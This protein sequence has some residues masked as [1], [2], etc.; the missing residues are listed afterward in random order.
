[1][2]PTF[3]DLL[4]GLRFPNDVTQYKD[5]SKRNGAF[6]AT[7]PDLTRYAVYDDDDADSTWEF[8]AP[9]SPAL[10]TRPKV[11]LNAVTGPTAAEK[12]ALSYRS[13]DAVDSETSCS[14]PSFTDDD[15]SSDDVADTGSEP[16]LFERDPKVR[17][18]ES[19][20]EAL[21]GFFQEAFAE[22]D[23]GHSHD[24]Q[25]LVCPR[26]GCRDTLQ[27][28]KALA[29]HLHLHDILTD[30]W[31]MVFISDFLVFDD[32]LIVHSSANDATA[33]TIPTENFNVTY[34]HAM[35]YNPLLRVLSK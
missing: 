3:Q 25:A 5:R 7:A 9:I 35:L 14:T 19:R 8:N 2:R 21:A 22:M 17:F 4:L 16:S 11:T 10:V 27:N 32:P 13:G 6:F 34:A 1:M 18:R 31:A 29:Y 26:S 12:I 20:C 23:K 15:D 28:V 33:G 30:W 24:G